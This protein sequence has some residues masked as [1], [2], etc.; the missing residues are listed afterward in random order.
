M[1]RRKAT[2]VW[3]SSLPSLW[4]HVADRTSLVKFIV[5][6]NIQIMRTTV[7][8]RGQVSV[9]S[10]I[11]KLLRIGPDTTLEWVLEGNSARVIPI[12]SDPI[13]AFRGSGKKGLVKQLLKDRRQDR[14]RED[15][16]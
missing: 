11:R 4:L 13:K 8:R 14:E 5:S 6:C 1:S 15:K 7:S 2:L 16:R 12:P 9:P 10:E 3:I